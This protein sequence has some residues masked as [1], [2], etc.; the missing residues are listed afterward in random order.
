MK[1]TTTF[2]RS[3]AVLG[4]FTSVMLAAQPLQAAMTVFDPSKFAQD[5][6]N[7]AL[8]AADR[9]QQLANWV[10]Q[11][12]NWKQNL[13]NYVRGKLMD[14]PGVREA[15]EKQSKQQMDKLFAERRKQCG[16]LSNPTSQTFCLRVVDLES[17]KYNILMDMDK[18]VAEAYRQVKAKQ[19]EHARADS[20]TGAGQQQRIEQEIGIIF[21]RLD[22]DIKQYMTNLQS[23]EAMI[24]EYQRARVMLTKNQLTGRNLG[25][26]IKKG[27]TAAVLQMQSADYRQKARERQNIGRSISNRF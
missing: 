16:N 27:S 25:N 5:A 1:P 26:S 13:A 22:A 17:D 18:K 20:K 23:K 3:K 4:I 11:L 6:A 15:I 12:D 7:W 8:D 10:A 2:K 14:I 19:Q 9:A 21:N 24:K